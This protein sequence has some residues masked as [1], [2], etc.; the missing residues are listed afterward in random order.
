MKNINQIGNVKN[1][2]ESTYTKHLEQYLY[3]GEMLTG[4]VAIELDEFNLDYDE[5]LGKSTHLC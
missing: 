3:L 4:N 2:D 5:V 1:I